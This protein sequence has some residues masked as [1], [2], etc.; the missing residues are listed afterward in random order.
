MPRRR[1]GQPGA[2]PPCQ[3]CGMPTPLIPLAAAVAL[4]P[5]PAGVPALHAWL[6]R[7]R[8]V[9]PATYLIDPASGR[10]HRVLTPGEVHLIRR[11]RLRGPGVTRLTQI[12]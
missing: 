6:Y 9:F 11:S 8:S 5:F 1:R 2:G 3:A 12:P 10:R 4:I 7:H